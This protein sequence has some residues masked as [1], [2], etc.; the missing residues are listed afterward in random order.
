MGDGGQA[1]GARRSSTSTRASPAPRAVADLHVPIRAGSDIA[2]LGGAG[3]PRAE[4]RPG[5]PRVRRGLHQRGDHHRRGLPRHRGPRRAVLR[6]RPRDR[7]TTT[8]RRWHYEPPSRATPAA[9]ATRSSTRTQRR[10]ASSRT[11]PA[12]SETHGS[13]GAAGAAGR[14]ERDETLQ[15]PRCVFQILKRH[16]ARYTPEMV[17]GG[18]RHRRRSSSPQVADALTRNSGPRAHHA[19][20]ATPSGWTHHTVGAQ[21]IRTAAILQTAARQHRPARRRDHGAARPRAASRARPTSRRCSTSCPATCPMPHADQHQSTSTSGVEDDEGKAGFWG[22]I[23][24]YAVSLLKAY[25]GDAATADNDF[26]FDYLPRLTGD[27]STYDDGQGADRG[28]GARATSWSG[29][30]PRSARPTA[31]CSG[32]GWPTS[33]GWS[34]ATCR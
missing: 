22:N 24:V 29:R 21:M 30:T 31:R 13:G 32:S 23:R 8:R 20:S 11:R 16:F 7:R 5:L 1:R 27:H 12:R 26:C 33:T 3:Q 34:C 19:R 18:V 6:L 17:A 28:R 25:W 14:A 15:H 9:S 4:Q 2:F 10:G